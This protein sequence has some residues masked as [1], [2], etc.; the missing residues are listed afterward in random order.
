MLYVVTAVHNRYQITKQFVEQLCRQTYQNITLLLVDDGSTDGTAD[1]VKALMPN[2]VIIQGDGNLWWGGALHLAYKWIKKN[3]SGSDYVWIANDDTAFADDY[4]EKALR[5]LERRGDTILTGYGVS[6]QTG[7]Q[8]DGAVKFVF[9]ECAG[10]TNENKEAFENCASTRSL[11]L[12]ANHFIKAGG[13]HPVLLPHYG[14]DYEWTIRACRRSKLKVY[15]TDELKYEANEETTGY[16]DPKTQS[17]KKIFS[18]KS[19]SNPFYKSNFALLAAPWGK[20]IAS[21]FVQVRR[22]V[23]KYLGRR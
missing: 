17:L 11:F 12:Q 20:K 19:M 2:S 1:M 3:A 15:C 5:I 8:V 13:F 22:L 7:K 21:G 18:K 14:S 4:C 9:P 10:Y 16:H 23:G 6:K